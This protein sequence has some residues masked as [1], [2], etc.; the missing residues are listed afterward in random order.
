MKIKPDSFA[1]SREIENSL[2]IESDE[3]SYK[4]RKHTKI[5]SAMGADNSYSTH[6]RF[7]KVP[8]EWFLGKVRT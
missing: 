6:T 8:I 7:S 3:T 2:C 1:I 5:S 4:M